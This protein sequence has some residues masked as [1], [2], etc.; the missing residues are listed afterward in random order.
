M[1]ALFA[2]TGYYSEELSQNPQILYKYSSVVALPQITGNGFKGKKI[3][4]EKIG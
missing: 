2:E 4:K 1:Y 3:K